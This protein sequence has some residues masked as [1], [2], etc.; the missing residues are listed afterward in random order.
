MFKLK[1][2]KLWLF[3]GVCFLFVGIMYLIEKRYSSG[4]MFIFL[5]VIYFGLSTANYKVD[6]KISKLGVQHVVSEEVEN[7]L[8]NLVAEGKKIEA[9]KKYR[10]IT[11]LGLKESKDYVDNIK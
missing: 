11:G 10:V 1:T 8:R 7:E 6:N 4:A 2:W 3:S 9:I 5:G